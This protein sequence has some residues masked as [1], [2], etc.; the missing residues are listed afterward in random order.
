MDTK[1]SSKKVWNLIKSLDG[2]SSKLHN[3]RT[4]TANQV[5]HQLL[6]NGKTN[7]ENSRGK[8]KYWSRINK[9]KKIESQSSKLTS[10]FFEEELNLKIV[11]IS[12]LCHQYKLFEKLILNRLGS[13]IDNKL[14]KE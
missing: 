7:Q 12:L 11:P 2:D 10:M 4:L 9:K 14:I 6:L 1:Y 3:T 5:A 13:I 8:R